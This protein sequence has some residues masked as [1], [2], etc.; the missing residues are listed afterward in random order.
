MNVHPT[1]DCANG[2][3]DWG[4]GCDP[5]G[6][7]QWTEAVTPQTPPAATG[8]PRQYTDG[9]AK[10]VIDAP[11]ADFRQN[12]RALAAGFAVAVTWPKGGQTFDGAVHM[13]LESAIEGAEESLPNRP[14][15]REPEH[16]PL[17]FQSAGRQ[18]RGRLPMECRVSCP[19]RK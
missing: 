9:T 3:L 6:R 2:P 10:L 4:C 1:S 13:D 16:P 7:A 8:W 14:A 15:S 17:D 5:I 12:F 19:R 18:F 11:Q